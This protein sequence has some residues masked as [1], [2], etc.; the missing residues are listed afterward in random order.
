MLITCTAFVSCLNGVPDTRARASAL[1][2]GAGAEE[3]A[4]SSSSRVSGKVFRVLMNEGR[5]NG[6]DRK[7]KPLY[8]FGERKKKRKATSAN[9]R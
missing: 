4:W 5:K 1:C 7:Q 6:E 9:T 2:C 8:L 3:R